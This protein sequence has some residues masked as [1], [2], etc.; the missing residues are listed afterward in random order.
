MY[1]PGHIA[2]G[3]FAASL[4][5]RATGTRKR[6]LYVWFFSMLPDVDLLLPFLD[7]RGATHSLAAALALAALTF[8]RRDLLPYAAAYA[9]HILVGDLVTGGSRLLW[10]LSDRVM[11]LD[12]LGQPSLTE[13]AVEI[14]LFAAMIRSPRFKKE[15]AKERGNNAIDPAM[16][17]SWLSFPPTSSM[18]FSLHTSG[19]ECMRQK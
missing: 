8:Y 2:L 17:L 15:W 3:Y 12:L 14:L 16:N 5:G 18:S 4:T 7:H 11:G 19:L 10:P 6:L 9:S 1:V 13:A